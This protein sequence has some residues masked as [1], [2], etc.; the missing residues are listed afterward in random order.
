M[1]LAGRH[2]ARGQRP[3][4]APG[5]RAAPDDVGLDRV[6]AAGAALA[7]ERVV[8]RGS[9]RRLP[10]PRPVRPRRAQPPAPLLLRAVGAQQPPHRRC[11]SRRH[12]ALRRRRVLLDADGAAW[13]HRAG[14]RPAH[15]RPARCVRVRRPRAQSSPLRHPG[16]RQARARAGDAVPPA[17]A[18]PRLGLPGHVRPD[19]GDG[20]DGLPADR[21]RR[22]PSV[23]DRRRDPGWAAASRARRRRL[24]PGDRR[25]RLLR[26][27]RDDGVREHTRRPRARSRAHRAAHR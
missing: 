5:P 6:A 14:R 7:R 9:H 16:R 15:L 20:P 4:A 26:A 11:R 27:Q 21:A 23:R 2:P 17:G 8:Q 22:T 12:R 19:R 18:T 25:A 10:R 13:R 1:G 24:R 3:R